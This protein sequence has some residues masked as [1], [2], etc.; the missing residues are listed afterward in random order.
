ML[1]APGTSGKP[2]AF[3]INRR[4]EGGFRL[5]IR[6]NHRKVCGHAPFTRFTLL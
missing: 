5:N 6:L 2:R 3:W 1:G 4:E